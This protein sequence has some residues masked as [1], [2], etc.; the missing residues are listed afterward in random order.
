MIVLNPT[1]SILKI[2]MKFKNIY[3]SDLSLFI[4][5]LISIQFHFP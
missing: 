3:A 4:P 2:K 5:W 1:Y